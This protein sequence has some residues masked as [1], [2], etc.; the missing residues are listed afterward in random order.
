MERLLLSLQLLNGVVWL[1]GMVEASLAAGS[2]PPDPPESQAWLVG[3][4]LVW[5]W[6][7]ASVI[8]AI[9]ILAKKHWGWWIEVLVVLPFPVLMFSYWREVIP[10]TVES[11]EDFMNV[12]QGVLLSIGTIQLLFYV[13]R[14]IG[15]SNASV[16]NETNLNYHP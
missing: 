11:L 12:V 13:A 8:A 2:F 7:V 6:C 3:A 4:H 9:A 16:A 5:I 10:F 15:K 1:F 14:R